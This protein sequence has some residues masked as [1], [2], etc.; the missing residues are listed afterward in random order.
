MDLPSKHLEN[1][2]KEDLSKVVSTSVASRRPLGE[3]L[4]GL[5]ALRSVPIVPVEHHYYDE[6]DDDE[7][8]DDGD[9]DGDD[10]CDDDDDEYD[11]GDD[12]GHVFSYTPTRA[13]MHGCGCLWALVGPLLRPL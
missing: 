12:D 10:E 6:D 7:D 4:R 9:D 5:L 3:P 8:D 2:K 13:S 11:D 1:N